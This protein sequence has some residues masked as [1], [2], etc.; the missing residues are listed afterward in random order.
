[1]VTKLA[2]KEMT[3]T[4]MGAWFLSFA[5]SNYLAAIIASATGGHEHGASDAAIAES[6]EPAN[7][8]ATYVDVYSTMGFITIGIG[9][10]LLIIS[11]FLNKMMHGVK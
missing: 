3:G 1:M 7:T 10:F 11:P 8:L 4:V 9:V 5:G 6:L 2:P